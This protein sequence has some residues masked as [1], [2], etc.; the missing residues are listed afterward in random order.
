MV[1]TQYGVSEQY[2]HS[3]DVQLS[4]EYNAFINNFTFQVYV[5][6]HLCGVIKYKNAHTHSYTVACNNAVGNVIKVIQDHNYLTLCEVQAFGVAS[7][8]HPGK[9]T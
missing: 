2:F 9:Q 6:G 1:T 8:A 7:A 4:Y 5:G 3:I